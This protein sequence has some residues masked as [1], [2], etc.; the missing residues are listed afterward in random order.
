[1]LLS[2]PV[3]LYGQLYFSYLKYV[4]QLLRDNYIVILLT[5]TQQIVNLSSNVEK[6]ALISSTH[7]LQKSQQERLHFGRTIRVSLQSLH[8][9]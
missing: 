6:M 5:K 3:K 1:M 7:L 4:V 9:L 2:E 8:L